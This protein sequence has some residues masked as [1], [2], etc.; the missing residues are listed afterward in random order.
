[1]SAII[2]ELFT[3]SIE[4][5]IQLHPAWMGHVSGLTAEKLLR[6][7]KIPYLYVLRQ[8]EQPSDYYVTYL[9]PDLSIAHR[10]FVITIDD[11]GWYYENTGGGGPYT[12]AG[13]EDVLHLIMHCGKDQC[14]PLRMA[15]DK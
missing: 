1:M 10:P 3:S 13:I 4:Y 5:G 8:G 14:V 15:H 12:N 11:S 7:R 2:Q 6:G 9:L